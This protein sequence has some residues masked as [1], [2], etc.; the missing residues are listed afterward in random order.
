MAEPNPAAEAA[1]EDL[2]TQRIIEQRKKEYCLLFV[3]FLLMYLEITDQG[4]LGAIR[5][6]IDDARRFVRDEREG[7]DMAVVGLIPQM[8][9]LCGEYHWNLSGEYAAEQLRLLRRQQAEQGQMQLLP[10]FAPPVPRPIQAER[11]TRHVRRISFDD[12]EVSPDNG[13]QEND[14]V[15]FFAAVA[16]E[17]NAE[18]VLARNEEDNVV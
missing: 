12:S 14:Y 11:P 9:R 6:L 3:R 16:S 5:A 7:T 18:N 2:E 8:R 1:A 13:Q 4:L 10:I 17:A 15:E